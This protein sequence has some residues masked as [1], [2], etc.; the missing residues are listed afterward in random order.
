[1]NSH[2]PLLT[3]RV[4]N[5][6]DDNAEVCWIPRYSSAEVEEFL[7][8]NDDDREKKIQTVKRWIKVVGWETKLI[9]ELS[10]PAIT[11]GMFNYMLIFVTLIFV[12]RL[13]DSQLAGASLA[14]LGLQGVAYAVMVC[15]IVQINFLLTYILSPI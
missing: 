15:I 7:R 12:G 1:M 3:L 4:D 14:C 6:D 5:E 11:S 8:K 9:W 2:Q 13:G 10:W